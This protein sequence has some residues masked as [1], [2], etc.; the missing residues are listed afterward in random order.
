VRLHAPLRR[1]AVRWLAGIFTAATLAAVLQASPARATTQS[2]CGVVIQS[3][4]DY[5]YSP[6]CYSGWLNAW[7]YDSASYPGSG[8]VDRLCVHMQHSTGNWF[9]MGW[10]GYDTNFANVCNYGV[11]GPQDRGWV[12]QHETSGASHTINGYVD[13]SPNHTG[14]YYENPT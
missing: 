13:D 7:T 5:N 14:C 4:T 8:V 10:C 3:S 9:A 2:Y 6:Q 1:R 12:R 11:L